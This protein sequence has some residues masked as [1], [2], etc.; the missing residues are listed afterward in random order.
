MIST[1][2][3]HLASIDG[4]FKTNTRTSKTEEI[5]SNCD[6]ELGPRLLN[7]LHVNFLSSR[8]VFCWTIATRYDFV[9][10]CLT[11][12][13]GEE[14]RGAHVRTRH[15]GVAHAARAV[16]LIPIPP[17]SLHYLPHETKQCRGIVL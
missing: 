2:E 11:S 12:N 17:C 7:R 8:P 4:Y 5:F 14:V 10:G 6:E 13:A 15:P 3:V 1:H 16:A 9:L